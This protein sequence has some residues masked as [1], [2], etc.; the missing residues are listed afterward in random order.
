MI[1]LR[2]FALGQAVENGQEMTEEYN[3]WTNRETWAV[4]LHIGN[5][6]GLQS[7]ALDMAAEAVRTHEDRN[8]ARWSLEDSLQSWV[9]TLLDARL[10]RAE[11]GGEQSEGLQMMSAE[12]GSL[13][14]VDWCECAESLLDDVEVTA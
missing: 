8:E 1:R 14:R 6:E 7:W 5:D 4:M 13:W 2:G 3:G 10:Y 9:E 11:F 12:V